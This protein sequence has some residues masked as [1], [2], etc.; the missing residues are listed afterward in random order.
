MELLKLAAAVC[1][2]SGCFEVFAA[3]TFKAVH[4]MTF[5]KSPLRHQPAGGAETILLQMEKTS[6]DVTPGD[7]SVLAAEMIGQPASSSTV[8][9]SSATETALLSQPAHAAW[10]DGFVD[11]IV[12]H[13]E[14]TG[15]YDA[16]CF[17]DGWRQVAAETVAIDPDSC[18]LHHNR[19]NWLRV[20]CEKA[21]P[22]LA[23]IFDSFLVSCQ[24][25]GGQFAWVYPSPETP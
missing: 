18:W 23:G 12:R 19:A 16:R 6:A 1:I 3:P 5:I 21:S 9:G 14:A 10:W 8:H 22:R 24:R 17:T 2:V 13:P 25:S 7:R 4:D 20:E 11:L 15:W